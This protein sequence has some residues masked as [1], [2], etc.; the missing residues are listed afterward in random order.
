MEASII[1][2]KVLDIKKGKEDIDAHILTLQINEKESAFVQFR[3]VLKKFIV[4]LSVGDTVQVPVVFEGKM[5][6]RSGTMYNN[7]VA[8]S[9]KK[10]S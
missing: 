3:K 2:G 9:L 4:G 8:K 6:S 10:V 5:S 7:L 1:T